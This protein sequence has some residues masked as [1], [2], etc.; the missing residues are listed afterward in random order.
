MKRFSRFTLFLLVVVV[1]MIAQVALSFP[2]IPSVTVTT[3]PDLP[4]GSYVL[5]RD[6][7][8][9][10]SFGGAKCFTFGDTAMSQANSEGKNWVVNTMY[11][12][13]DS[14]PADGISGGYNFKTSGQPAN[15][16][17]PYAGTEGTSPLIGLWPC[18]PF[19]DPNTGKTYMWFVKVNESVNP[20]TVY[21]TGFAQV[22]S[23]T[24]NPT[25]IQH[26]SGNAQPYLMFDNSEGT[27]GDGACVVTGGYVYAFFINGADWGKVRLA[28]CSLTS[29]QFKTRS[30]WRFWDGSTWVATISSAAVITDGCMGGSIEWNPYLNCWLYCYMGWLSDKLYYRVA[31]NLWGPWSAASQI[32][33][34]THSSNGSNPYSGRAHK[35]YEQESGRTQYVS[36][37]IP[38]E[39]NFQERVCFL[40]IRF[41]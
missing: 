8:G 22:T 36:Y 12:T 37:A 38:M 32:Y 39:S 28:R 34:G 2:T 29:E 21:G 41:N 3:L 15:Q 18:S 25:R 35:I 11:R 40:K 10:L 6:T 4:K 30:N 9:S 27:Y 16:W 1:F 24:T 23:L 7:G 5:G 33:V 26:R 13:T 19:V 17:I 20:F 31:D 14:N